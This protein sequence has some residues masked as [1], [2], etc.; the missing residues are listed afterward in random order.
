MWAQVI[1]ICCLSADSS[2]SIILALQLQGFSV[3]MCI[4]PRMWSGHQMIQKHLATSR[5]FH[6]DSQKLLYVTD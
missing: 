3:D 6:Q 4:R 5:Q 1:W 2:C